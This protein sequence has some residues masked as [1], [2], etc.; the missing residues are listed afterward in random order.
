M[1]QQMNVNLDV[2]TRSMKMMSPSQL[3]PLANLTE[4]GVPNPEWREELEEML[5]A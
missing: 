5:S 2:S 4:E 1:G 3:L